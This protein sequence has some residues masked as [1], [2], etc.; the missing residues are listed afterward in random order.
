MTPDEKQISY[1]AGFNLKETCKGSHFRR[2]IPAAIEEHLRMA[3]EALLRMEK[4][5]SWQ[6]SHQESEWKFISPSAMSPFIGFV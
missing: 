5:A 3:K 1:F 6:T 4:K 2:R